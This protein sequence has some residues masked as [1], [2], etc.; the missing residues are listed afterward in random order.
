M[1]NFMLRRRL[2][3]GAAYALI[4]TGT[5]ALAQ[6]GQR[7]EFVVPAESLADALKEVARQSG[8]EIVFPA[9]AV[10]G[11]RAPKLRGSYTVA[12]AVQLLLRGTDLVARF[13]DG[14]ILIQG[15][16]APSG[17][18][19]ARPAESTGIVVTGSRIAGPTPL[20][21]TI[22]LKQRE[23]Q[24]AGFSNLG[25]V[26][27]SIPQNFSGGQN[28]TVAGG[29]NQGGTNQNTTSS[30]TLNLRGLG[31]DAT[32][33]LL[34]GHRLP[35][36]AVS[37]GV[38]ISAIP[39]VAID[40]IEIVTDG[41]SAI[42]GSDAVAGVAN[43]ILKRSFNGVQAS[44]RAGLSTDGGNEQ[45]QYSL[46]AGTDWQTGGLLVTGDFSRSTH[47]LAGDRKVTRTLHPL[48]T[49]VPSLKQ[50]TAI[51]SGYQQLGDAVRLE[52]DATWMRRESRLQLASS[53]T[54]SYLING[55]AAEPKI[56]SFSVSP[57]LA[58]DIAPGWEAYIEGTYGESRTKVQ[59]N[60]YSAGAIAITALVDYNDILKA[61]E[62]GI[63]GSLASLPGG[64]LQIAL[65]GGYR[66]NTLDL[67][68]RS[69]TAG[70]TRVSA[71]FTRSRA[72]SYGFAEVRAPIIEPDNSVPF[73]HRLTLSGAVR[74]EHYE[75]FGG[76]ATPKLGILYSPVRDIDLKASWGQ[77]FKSPTLYQ[78]FQYKSVALR[79]ATAYGTSA[80]PAGS[81]VLHMT[82]GNAE[83]LQ[84][85]RAE[86]LTLALAW[87]PSFLPGAVI[88][89]SYFD[90]GYRDR[91]IAPIAS[92][93]GI[94]SDPNYA[95]LITRS[96]TADQVT[97]ALANAP[98]GLSNQAGTPFDATRVVAIVDNRQRNSTRQ[99][100]KGFDLSVRYGFG[101]GST[102]TLTLLG[103]GSY[104]ESEQVLVEGQPTV[105]L[106]GTIFRA[107]HWRARGG[108]SWQDGGLTVT[109]YLNYVGGTEDRRVTPFVDVGSFTTLDTAI[110]YRV[111][112]EGSP[113]HRL[114]LSLAASNLLNTAPD[115]IRNSLATDP[116][117]DSTNYSPVGRFF[118]FTVRKQW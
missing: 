85:E 19:E 74:Y 93:L 54:A 112:A 58:L 75:S 12:E 39:L 104:I 94:F 62:A 9:A 76:V 101:I 55:A 72:S 46:A 26:I 70:T 15:R 92:T 98:A 10:E 73:I 40:R 49:L 22:V 57:S 88:E 86:N 48:A 109:S 2:M 38:D 52:I 78:E 44:A 118:S 65:G 108:L 99:A 83:G 18:V 59:T 91:I 82:G 50:S 23:M 34:N 7:Q 42:Y 47:I 84:P 32:L 66:S 111:D 60:V 8:R 102:G 28:P 113:F 13:D 37:Q 14:G 24:D 36:D 56:S 33:T 3:T 114:E 29:G 17:E 41:A 79:L 96:P 25:D 90:V 117:Y 35:Y 61:G 100:I 89:A 77:S 68:T 105:Q 110:T 87:R 97:A 27:R 116:T 11:K 106:A 67:F 5:V 71:D 115:R 64:T 69:I 80:F 20:S 1:T 4:L 51:L 21:P 30:S 31:P 107:P 63:T 16:S 43:I 95:H 103:S 53:T 81:T 45:Q 6:G